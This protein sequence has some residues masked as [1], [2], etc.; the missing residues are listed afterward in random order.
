MPHI[1][2]KAQIGTF[3]KA[4]NHLNSGNV[5]QHLTKIQSKL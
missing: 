4:T 2:I 3:E 1:R 5:F